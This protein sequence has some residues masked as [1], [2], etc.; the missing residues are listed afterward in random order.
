[1]YYITYRLTYKCIIIQN[2]YFQFNLAVSEISM[3]NHT[4]CLAFFNFNY[5]EYFLQFTLFALYNIS[6]YISSII[7][8]YVLYPMSRIT[9]CVVT[10]CFSSLIRIWLCMQVIYLYIFKIIKKMT[11]YIKITFDCGVKT[12]P[13]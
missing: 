11:F 7:R 8:E 13:N 1:M 12:N 9:F 4:N 10:D 6:T 5:L 3:I 2:K